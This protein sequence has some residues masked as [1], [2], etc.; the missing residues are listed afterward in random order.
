MSEIMLVNDISRAYGTSTRG[1]LPGIFRTKGNTDL[2]HTG[3]KR[4]F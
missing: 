3:K 4:L 2:C 1:L